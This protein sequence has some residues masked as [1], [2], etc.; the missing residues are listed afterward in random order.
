MGLGARWVEK[1]G[2]IEWKREWE[3]E[4]QREGRSEEETTADVWR[5]PEHRYVPVL[6]L[7]VGIEE[8]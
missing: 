4:D 5:H 2:Q 7:Q 8:K 3:E 1:T 6:D